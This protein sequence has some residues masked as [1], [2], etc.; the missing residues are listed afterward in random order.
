MR[1]LHNPALRARLRDLRPYYNAVFRRQRAYESLPQPVDYLLQMQ[2]RGVFL[3]CFGRSGS[4]VF[5]DFMG[6]HPQVISVGEVL[7]EESYYSYFQWLSHGILRLWPLRPTLMAREFYRFCASLVGRHKGMH[8][9]FDLK[10]ESLHL[11]DGN[12][13][14]PGPDFQIFTHLRKAQVPVILLTR[15]DLVARYVS[16]QVAER[17]GAYHSYQKAGRAVE[18]FAIDLDALTCQ[19]AQID[20]THAKIRQAFAGSDHLLE[21][22]YE[23]MLIPDPVTGQTRFAPDLAPKIAGLLQIEDRFDS[24]PRLKKL[25][26]DSYHSLVTNWAEVETIQRA[27]LAKAQP[28]G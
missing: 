8:C 26:A 15:R 22:A 14:M 7:G 21:I 23:D 20:A 2:G 11:I 24:M 28:P 27:H 1:L 9:L 17:R 18:P 6:S 13:R 25:S 19:I 10:I 12:W 16:G 4:T 3:L 5:A